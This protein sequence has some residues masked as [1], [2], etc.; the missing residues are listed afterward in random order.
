MRAPARAFSFFLAVFYFFSHVVFGST[1]EMSVWSERRRLHAATS[2]AAAPIP[3]L[4]STPGRPDCLASLPAAAATLQEVWDK[5]NPGVSPVIL[6][7]DIHLNAEA[8]ENI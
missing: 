6:I 1:A 3:S 5:G 7:Q 8:Q 4:L 2:L